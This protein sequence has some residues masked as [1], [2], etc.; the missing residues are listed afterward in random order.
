M[1]SELKIVDDTR[2]GYYITLTDLDKSDETLGISITHEYYD[3]D[4]LN[5]N[6]ESV[7]LTKSDAKALVGYLKTS[8]NL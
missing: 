5:T 8:F 7:W 2:S 4:E 1:A 6:T 3:K